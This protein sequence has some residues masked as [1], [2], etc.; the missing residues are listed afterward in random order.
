MDN[1]VDD[2]VALVEARKERLKSDPD[3]VRKILAGTV[4]VSEDVTVYPNKALNKRYEEFNARI[5]ELGKKIARREGESNE[6]HAARIQEVK[7][8][9][10]DATAEF[11][12][13]KAE[14]AESAV[15]FTLTSLGKKAVKNIRTAARKKF[16]LPNVGEYEDADESEARDDY[17]H[18][19][20]IAAHLEKDGYTIEDVEKMQDKWPNRAYAQLWTAVQRLSIADDYLGSAFN[21]DF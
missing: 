20:L 19:A 18:N 3:A 6:D 10:E 14:I 4:E 5:V 8:E 21:S 11:E 9:Y 2:A 1:I 17:Y 13:L 16:P 7:A 12:A 15:T